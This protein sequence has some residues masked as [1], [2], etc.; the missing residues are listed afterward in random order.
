LREALGRYFAL[1]ADS[2]IRAEM[3]A[4]STLTVEGDDS[5]MRSHALLVDAAVAG[6]DSDRGL[7]DDLLRPIFGRHLARLGQALATQGVVDSRLQSAMRE[8]IGE[9]AVATARERL[10]R[11]APA[12]LEAAAVETLQAHSERLAAAWYMTDSPVAIWRDVE[13]LELIARAEQRLAELARDPRL[14]QDLVPT[15][16]GAL[17]S[18]RASAS[19]LAGRLVAW[20]R[21]DGPTLL[22]A[23]EALRAETYA[24]EQDKPVWS[25]GYWLSMIATA[26]GDAQA[27]SLTERLVTSG[28]VDRHRGAL[29]D[30]LGRESLTPVVVVASPWLSGAADVELTRT[31]PGV[32]GHCWRGRALSIPVEVGERI[33]QAPERL[34]GALIHEMVEDIQ[35]DRPATRQ[36]SCL[37]A[38]SDWIGEGATELLAQGILRS[39]GSQPDETRPV[40]YPVETILVEQ[41]VAALGPERRRA[42][43][44]EIVDAPDPLSWLASVWGGDAAQGNER[45]VAEALGDARADLLQLAPLGIEAMGSSRHE[46]WQ[47]DAIPKLAWLRAAVAGSAS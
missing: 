46:Q 15:L 43:L 25:E 26:L 4:L 42:L 3:D 28:A 10:P 2:G 37:E 30:A 31:N 8:L 1:R 22:G 11:L 7:S 27:R 17:T 9:V 40:G 38:A 39:S 13:E 44:L 34:D 12:Y 33:R 35:R 21:G 19:E 47:T 6:A 20:S 29:R 5:A 45:S 23:G 14:P 36:D 16:E 32:H 18:T 41:L 24:A